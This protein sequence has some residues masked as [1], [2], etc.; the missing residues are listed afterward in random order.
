[1]DTKKIEIPNYLSME[2]IIKSITKITKRYCDNVNVIQKENV[3]DVYYEKQIY[4]Y[5]TLKY[6]EDTY[7]ERSG[8]T[9]KILD[10]K[11]IITQHLAT[12]NVDLKN[13]FVYIT[14]HDED[15]ESLYRYITRDFMENIMFD[16]ILIER[17]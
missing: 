5:K 9:K 1:M 12:F 17:N 4:I 10:K 7:E 15:R 3:I 8:Q 13:G 16:Y 2:Y 11:E 6:E 14:I